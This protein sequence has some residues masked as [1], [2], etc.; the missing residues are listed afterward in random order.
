MDVR[1]KK[2]V[3]GFAGMGVIV[4][5]VL[6][7]PNNSHKAALRETTMAKSSSLDIIF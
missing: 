7:W 1:F 4:A 6:F 3:V 2:V 5:S